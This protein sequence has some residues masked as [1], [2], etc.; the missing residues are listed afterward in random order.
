MTMWTMSMRR[1][2]AAPPAA[3]AAV[4]ALTLLLLVAG[5]AAPQEPAAGD[6]GGDGN[7][8]AGTAVP[9]G[10]AGLVAALDFLGGREAFLPQF[11]AAGDGTVYV[12]WIERAEGRGSNIFI[13]RRQPD[14][15]FGDPVQVNDI[16][17]GASGG[18]L[19]E[20]RPA[21][22]TGGDGTV[23]ISWTARG[24]DVRAALSHDRGASFDPS[25]KLN[26]DDGERVYR[27]FGG[28]AL[29]AAGVAHA[30]WI[31]A[32]FAPR[33]A[34]EPADLMYARIEGDR[35]TEINLTGA[36]EDS[37][38]GCCRVSV[39]VRADDTVVIAFRNTGGGYRDIFRV[40]AGA[41]RAFGTPARLGPPMWELRGCPVI[42]PLNVGEATL[43]AEAS[44]GKRRILG[45]T[46]TSGAYE[47][48]I[49]D[50]DAWAIERPPRLVAGTGEGDRMLLLPGRP[51]GRVL[52]GAGTEWQVV[53]V[54]VP[55][56]AMS[57]TRVDGALVVLGAYDG[58]VHVEALAGPF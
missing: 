15:T 42:G 5:C 30:A 54:E 13:A 24:G 27:G 17:G 39:A 29:D 53:E 41:D 35:V 11:A 14:G 20:A 21:V 57:A 40:E 46:D 4:V 43:W 36:Q 45:A 44:T 49:E 10:A 25:V 26:S 38:C 28:L 8:A 23:A 16:D 50:D 34:E 48:V 56:W 9:D 2:S 7:G 32:R 1:E 55:R 19:D 12:V 18:S 37:I 31:D 58:E 52:R 51:F 3:C 6:P 22:A 33:G 47:V